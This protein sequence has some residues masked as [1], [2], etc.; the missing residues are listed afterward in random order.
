MSCVAGDGLIVC[1]AS[2]VRKMG[3]GA[4]DADTGD[5]NG[6]ISLTAP[7]GAQHAGGQ[8]HGPAGAGGAMGRW[9]SCEQHP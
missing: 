3:S 9:S 4:K 8:P 5:A 1:G 6:Q 7:L 2:M